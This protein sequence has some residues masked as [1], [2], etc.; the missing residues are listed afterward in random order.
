MLDTNAVVAALK[1]DQRV[2]DRLKALLP[3]DVGT[4]TVTLAE[5]WFGALKSSRPQQTRAAVDAF[6]EPL[7]VVPFDRAAAEHCA[8]ARRHLEKVGRPIGERDL[9]I[10]AIALSREAVVVTHNVREF[11]RVPG[12]QHE[13]WMANR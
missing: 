1:K 11:E 10:A 6:L 7:D 2:I 3:D 5:L 9:L 12:L 8:V 13:D 4:T